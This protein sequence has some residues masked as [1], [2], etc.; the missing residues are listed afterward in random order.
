[1][2]STI[3]NAEQPDDLVKQSTPF[4]Y[5]SVSAT[6]NDGNV[7][8]HVQIYTDISGEFT[9]NA[10]DSLNI[11]WNTSTGNILTHQIQLLDPTVLDEV[12]DHAKCRSRSRQQ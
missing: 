11:T 7:S 9:S 3:T 1:V 8:H 4:S 2:T 10:V 5:L 12:N 6:P